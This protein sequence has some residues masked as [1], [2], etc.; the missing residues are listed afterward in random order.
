ML[1]DVVEAADE[2]G[3]GLFE[4]RV[5]IYLVETCCVDEREEEVAELLRRA[6]LVL[7][8]QFC[9]QL[10]E[11]L[12]HLSP[13]IAFVL[14]VEAHIA[15]LV[16]HAIRLDKRRQSVGHTGKHTLVAVLLLQ[17]Q[18][19]PLLRHLLRCLR[20]VLQMLVSLLAVRQRFRVGRT[21]LR[22][23][24]HVRMTIDE[25]V[26]ELIAHVGNVKFAL[27]FSDTSVEANV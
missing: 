24:V 13:H 10:V 4:C 15:H 1:L 9:L 22:G 23:M 17:L 12:A 11:F 26:D 19:L 7:T 21:N 25:L 18:L 6:F 5:G 2:L 20:R 16:L 14:P 3:V 27:F 8:A